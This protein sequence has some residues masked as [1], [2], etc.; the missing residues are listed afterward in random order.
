MLFLFFPSNTRNPWSSCASPLPLRGVDSTWGSRRA[1]GV[2][3][4]KTAHSGATL[5]RLPGGMISDSGLLSLF[6]SWLSI[7][8]SF[9]GL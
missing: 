6:I 5:Y 2:I 9:Y 8:I 1:L 3:H 4:D 7:V